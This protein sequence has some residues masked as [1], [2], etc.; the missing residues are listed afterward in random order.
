[1]PIFGPIADTAN[2]IIALPNGTKDAQGNRF[3]NTFLGNSTVDDVGFIRDLL[4]SLQG[5]Y[6]IDSN[7][8]YSTGMS[9]GGFMSYSLACELGDRI[10][11]YCF[12]YRHDDTIEAGRLQ[13]GPAGTGDANSRYCRQHGALQ[14]ISGQHFCEHSGA[15]GY[16]G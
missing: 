11:G 14:R 8:V 5:T 10:T 2:F 4:N 16:L 9:N 6:N 15:G 12:R 3:W 7:R 13:S 1:M